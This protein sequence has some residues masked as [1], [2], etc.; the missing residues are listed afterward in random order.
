L[1]KP[2]HSQIIETQ[3]TKFG[4]SFPEWTVTGRYVGSEPINTQDTAFVRGGGWNYCLK[5]RGFQAFIVIIIGLVIFGV[6]MLNMHYET[7][8]VVVPATIAGAGTVVIGLAAMG[9]APCTL[10]RIFKYRLGRRAFHEGDWEIDNRIAALQRMRQQDQ[11]VF[12]QQQREEAERYR[13]STR[14][15]QKLI[16]IEQERLDMAKDE[17]AQ[18]L[19]ISERPQSSSRP[20]VPTAPLPPIPPQRQPSQGITMQT[21]P[22]APPVDKSDEPQFLGPRV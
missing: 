22:S 10:R 2:K 19:S 14:Q 17:A 5:L 15:M 4:S 21:Y 20:P 6:L 12:A 7:T 3:Q 9:L 8:N 1:A 13:D 18:R 11:R 16:A